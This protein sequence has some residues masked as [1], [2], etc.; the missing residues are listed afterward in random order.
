VSGIKVAGVYRGEAQFLKPGGG[1][2]PVLRLPMEVTASPSPALALR[3]ADEKIKLMAVNCGAMDCWLARR[4]VP[5]A[6]IPAYRLEMNSNALTPFNVQARIWGQGE[7]Y[8]APLAPL[9]PMPETLVAPPQPIYS[10]ELKNPGGPNAQQIAPDRYVG[11]LQL[12]PPAPDPAVSVP[13]EIAVRNGPGWPV[14]VLFLGLLLGRLLKYMQDKGK[15]QSD[16]LLQYYR[17]EAR[18]AAEP[19]DWQILHFQLEAVKKRIENLELDRA[20]TDLAA[21]QRQSDVLA[22]LREIE[23]RL[24]EYREHTGAGRV[25]AEIQQA[26]EFIALGQDPSSVLGQIESDI[27]A[28]ATPQAPAAA[29]DFQMAAASASS[30]Q[31]ATVVPIDKQTVASKPSVGARVFLALTGITGNL[32]AEATLWILRPILFLLLLGALLVVGMKQLYVN[33]QVFGAD[34]IGDYFALF[35]WS[36]GSD[37]ASRALSSLRL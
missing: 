3:K 27:R 19:A 18:I 10:L 7:L 29:R 28:L 21:V 32:R 22:H 16:L 20:R 34:W 31:Q 35:I 14:F 9:L 23:Q 11:A 24:A 1:L 36:T 37:Q 4:L 17:L 8:H 33:D 25:L 2:D 30:A 5:A 13:V 6:F 26:R 12:N 15:P